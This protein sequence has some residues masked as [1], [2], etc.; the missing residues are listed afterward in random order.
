MKISPH[1]ALLRT[2]ATPLQCI[3]SAFVVLGL[4]M[5]A[6]SS[7]APKES[8]PLNFL[9]IT[10][11]DLEWSSVGVY[12]SS[13]DDI[14]PNLDRLA[15]QGVRFTNAH[16]TIA[17]CQPSRQTLVTGRYPHN[18]GAPGFH[19]IADDVPILQESLRQA[20]Y[21]NA[22]VG[23]AR[24]MQPTERFGW[25]LGPDPENP[26]AGVWME[27]LGQ[28]R[29]IELYKQYVSRFLDKART[30]ERPFWLN[31]NTHDPHRPFFGMGAEKWDYPVSREYSPDEIEVPG[32]LPDLPEIREELAAY[33]TSAHR[34][35]DI[36]GA[37]LDLLDEAG[38]GDNTLVMFLSDNGA[39]FPFSKANTYL[40]S[41]KTPWIV[42]FPGT[43]APGTVDTTHF[44][45]GIDYMPTILEAAGL[46]EVENMDGHSFLSILSGERQVWR[47]SVF[48]E[49]NK[50]FSGISL[51]MRGIQNKDFGYIY[52]PFHSHEQVRMDSMSGL[53]WKAM[54]EAGK[55]NPEIQKRVDLFRDRVPEE[56]YAYRN[57]PD[58]LVNLIDDPEYAD[59]LRALRQ[60][61]ANEMFMTRDS[62]LT[63]FE[64]E[65]G[66]RGEA[67]VR[68]Y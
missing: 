34:A 23:K 17:V 54:V 10:A 21:L 65:F 66:I 32:F 5:T 51:H 49:F 62:L 39:S 8:E 6:C 1:S 43:I 46:A 4:M 33:F 56:L 12:G 41:T 11:D 13:V 52:N 3:W 37:V 59:V 20:G 57:D 16:V 36:I 9:L 7:P 61:L 45:S 38:Y 44:I 47:N 27:D 28:G 60:E 18:N 25:D 58:G 40:N 29:D 19:P 30:E 26:G 42:R 63:Q 35:D 31:L 24:H 68:P 67:I 64:D 50:P 14:T 2:C 15:S 53:T 55:T 22:I 48:T